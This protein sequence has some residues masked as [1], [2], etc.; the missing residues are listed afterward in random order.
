MCKHWKF[1]SGNSLC[2]LKALI[3]V[4]WTDAGQGSRR[5][6]CRYKDTVCGGRDPE[7]SCK[8]YFSTPEHFLKTWIMSSGWCQIKIVH[9][10]HYDLSIW[11]T[12]APLC[13]CRTFVWTPSL[14]CS[15]LLVYPWFKD[16]KV[17]KG[18]RRSW[19]LVLCI[20]MEYE[21]DLFHSTVIFLKYV[22]SKIQV[23]HMVI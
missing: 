8:Y 7:P 6:M 23:N 5:R 10:R 17:S 18:H 20:L 1:L 4:V 14:F 22:Q 16:W 12:E 15:H 21:S 19:L 3:T 2:L 13:F 9:R 11:W